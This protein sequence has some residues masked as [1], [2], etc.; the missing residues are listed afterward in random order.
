MQKIKT[1]VKKTIAY[2]AK[3]LPIWKR[4]LPVLALVFSPK[5]RRL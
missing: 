5:N 4:T 3:S 2:L 1:T